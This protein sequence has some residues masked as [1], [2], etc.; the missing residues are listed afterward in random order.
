M[1]AKLPSVATSGRTRRTREKPGTTRKNQGEQGE[2]RKN[3]EGGETRTLT[4]EETPEKTRGQGIRA[5]I[6]CGGVW[7][8]QAQG[9][10]P[11]PCWWEMCGG[12]APTG[13]RG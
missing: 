12:E 9:V 4:A 8:R 13:V 10:K 1:D 5:L 3:Q 6:A 2:A 7:W 11:A